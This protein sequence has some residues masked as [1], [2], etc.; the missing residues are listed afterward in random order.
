[1]NLNKSLSFITFVAL[2]SAAAFVGRLA[3]QGI[4]NVQPLTDVI[5]MS[6]LFVSF[7][8]GS[9]VAIISLFISNIY[10]GMGIW[11]IAQ[12]L[13]Y[14]TLCGLIH[15]CHMPLLGSS[16]LIRALF[17]GF[18]GYL[19]GLIISLVQAPFFGI[20]VFWPYYLQGLPFDTL[21]A[22]GNLLFYLIL[23]PVMLPIFIKIQQKLDNKTLD[24]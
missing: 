9:L 6:V 18:L 7:P 24:K 21:H 8:F 10:L 17:A 19:Y 11:T 23:E 5:M 14:L 15:L 20:Q 3:F 2:I 1:M 16:K 12:L 22:I 13:S 4:P